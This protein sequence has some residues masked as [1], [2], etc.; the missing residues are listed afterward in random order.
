M[1]KRIPTVIVIFLVWISLSFLST[2]LMFREDKS[3]IGPILLEGIAHIIFTLVL[4]TIFLLIFYWTIKRNPLGR[5]LTLIYYPVSV[6][7][8]LV[9]IITF[10]INKDLM[11]G[12]LSKNIDM[13]KLADLA[14]SAES[15][16]LSS[17]VS[18]FLFQLIITVLIVILMIKKKGY[19]I[20]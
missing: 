5:K 20:Y 15:I 4:L 12:F 18:S 11:V 3:F 19:F 7:I 13:I 16:I 2:L 10:F 6:L 14:I 8:L 17:L 9:N 1:N